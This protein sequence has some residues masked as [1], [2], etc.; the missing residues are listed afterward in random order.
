M[1]GGRLWNIARR[2]RP[3]LDR[4]EG[5]LRRFVFVEV[6]AVMFTGP[7]AVVALITLVAIT[8]FSTVTTYPL[9]GLLVVAAAWL[10][11]QQN[12]AILVEV[13]GG[14][15]VPITGSLGGIVVW[16]TVLIFGPTAFWL[17][18]I[19]AAAASILLA[20]RLVSL[21]RPVFWTAISPFC[22]EAGGAVFSGL[23]G[24]GVFRLLGGSYP[25]RL[26]DW[27]PAVAGSLVASVLPTLILFPIILRLNRLGASDSQP[28]GMLH[29]WALLVGFAVLETPFSILGALVYSEGSAGLFVVFVGEVVLVNLLTHYLSQTN[30]R[31]QQRARELARLEALGEA[32]I[33]A[34]PDLST[35]TDLLRMYVVNMFPQDH[36]ELRLFQPDHPLP[37]GLRWPDFVLPD[38]QFNPL[39]DPAHWDELKRSGEPT[40]VLQ[41]VSPPGVK[42]SHGGLLVKIMTDDPGQEGGEKE[43]LLGGIGL[44]RNRR[45]GKPLPSLP[46]VQALASQIGSAFYRAMANLE[47]IAAH[48]MAQELDLAGH[49][50][51][52]FLPRLVPRPPGWDIAAALTPA[53]QTSGDFYDFVECAEN[54]LGLLVA[55]V[56][57]KGTGA[58]LYMA[59][60]RTLLR[61]FA[62]SHPGAPHE[63]LRAANER[64][65]TDAASDQFVTVLYGV[66]DLEAGVMFYANAGHNPGYLLRGDSDG[67]SSVESLGQTGMPLG[68]FDGLRWNAA[69]AR[70][71]PGD[72]LVLYTDGLSEAQ[73]PGREEFGVER[74]LET[75]RAHL[76]ST[77]QEIHD[78]L[79]A[80]VQ[81]FVG[82]APQFD[83]LTLVVVKRG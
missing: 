36:V 67:G 25:L 32:L 4:T 82:D 66:L 3:E 78:A 73:N 23:V 16:S 5:Q 37:P 39:V 54:R 30:Q 51:S 62:L 49:I 56:A 57:D 21:K 45:L 8:D 76:H 12:F 34:P 72:V 61:T 17:A 60:T 11:Q 27:L 26:D 50:Q 6:L 55:D 22:Q 44:L 38:L 31:S 75:V 64:I 1:T 63:A 2:L 48:R 58:A 46:A 69:H 14:E 10:M 65:L 9:L 43:W 33:Q 7:L 83:D 68:M 71:A 79:L 42:S 40:M 59:L 28:G 81:Q 18:L 77:A 80:A 70:I 41:R 52:S 15:I 53:R 24:V 35:L 29:W 19:V 74:L 47:A 20:G 13:G